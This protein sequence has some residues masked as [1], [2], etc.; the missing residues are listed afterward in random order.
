[1]PPVVEEDGGIV[2]LTVADALN[3]QREQIALYGGGPA[4]VLRPELLESAVYAPRATFDGHPL[5]DFPFEM[6]AV[7][8]VHIIKNHPLLNANKRTGSMSAMEFLRHN[9]HGFGI[10]T[11]RLRQLALRAEADAEKSEIAK[12]LR[13]LYFAAKGH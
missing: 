11:P 1:M 3:I 8:M 7:Y 6:A 10:S 12:Q 5:Y 13:S 4:G 9:G 2:F